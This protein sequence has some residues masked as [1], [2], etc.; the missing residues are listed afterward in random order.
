M[1]KTLVPSTIAPPNGL[2]SHGVVVPP[3]ARWVFTAGQVGVKSDGTLLEGFAAQHEQAWH[4]ALAV[5]AAGGMGPGDIVR[6]NV[7]STDPS[8][9][10]VAREQRKQFLKPGHVPASTWV[11][12]KELANPAW[13]V[14]V[15]MV[16]AKA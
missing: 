16:A 9:L 11:I 1:L 15:E 5:L 6:I 7:Y 3:N 2:Y 14:E 10:A 13:L 8:G 4:N 12:V